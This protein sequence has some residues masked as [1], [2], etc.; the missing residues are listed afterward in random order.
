MVTAVDAW[1]HADFLYRNY[2]LNG[3][4]NTLYTVYCSQKTTKELWDSL[5]MKYMTEDNEMKKFVVGRFL[6]YKMAD[7]KTIISLVQDL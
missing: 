1:K 6:D 3:L 4:D 5:N 7:S 2:I